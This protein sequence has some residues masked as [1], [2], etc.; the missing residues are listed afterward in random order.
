MADFLHTINSLQSKVEKLVHL[1]VKATEDIEKLKH[2]KEA[3]NAE[4]EKQKQIFVKLEETN[5]IIKLSKTIN[6]KQDNTELKYKI[7]ELV[8][9][10]DK[11]MALLN[12]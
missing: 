11:C 3:I 2:E 8:R 1:H 6:N 4:L 9:E 5:K 7:N 10:I 12:N